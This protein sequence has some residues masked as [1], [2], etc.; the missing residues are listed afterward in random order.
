MPINRYLL[1]KDKAFTKAL[2]K[3]FRDSQKRI[4]NFL[5]RQDKEKGF[6]EDLDAIL[7]SII[8]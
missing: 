8:V 4:A 1:Q 3:Y 6:S 2:A 7:T 5:I